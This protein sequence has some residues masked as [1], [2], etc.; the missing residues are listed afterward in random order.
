MSVLPVDPVAVESASALGPSAAAQRHAELV[1]AVER[2]NRLYYQEDAPEISDAEYDALFRELVAVETA[3]PELRS[4]DSPTQRV[5][6]GPVSATFDEV[7]HRHPMLSLANAFSH[8][9]IGRAHV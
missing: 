1:A 2:A 4:P 3:F 7:R 9:E 6:G 5:G 8:D